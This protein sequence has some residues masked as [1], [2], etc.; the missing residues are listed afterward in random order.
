[1]KRS[2]IIG[3]L[4]GAFGAVGATFAAYQIRAQLTEELGLPDT[5]VALVEDATALWAGKAVCQ[6][7]TLAARDK[8]QQ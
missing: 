1:M 7:L 8:I 2:P 6:G 3:A 5:A 4:A